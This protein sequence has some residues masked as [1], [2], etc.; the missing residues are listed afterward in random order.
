VLHGSSEPRTMR[1]ISITW[2]RWGQT[3][4]LISSAGITN[5]LVHMFFS[6]G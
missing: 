6:Q 5:L 3:T 1:V 4:R 2:N